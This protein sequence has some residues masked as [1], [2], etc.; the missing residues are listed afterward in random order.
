MMIAPWGIVFFRMS[1]GSVPFE[2][3][4]PHIR[5]VGFLEAGDA[6]EEAELEVELIQPGG[7]FDDQTLLFAGQRHLGRSA[8]KGVHF[9]VDL[10]RLDQ[11]AVQITLK[12]TVRKE[13][14]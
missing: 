5:R 3:N 9:T 13:G 7:Q 10:C 11:L 4:V 12:G 1:N 8:V 14:K 6:F 2:G